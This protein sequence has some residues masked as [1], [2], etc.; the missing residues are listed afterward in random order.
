MSARPR[1]FSSTAASSPLAMPWVPVK[2]AIRSSAPTPSGRQ[3]SA[4]Q[5]QIEHLIRRDNR[6][7]PERTYPFSPPAKQP[8]KLPMPSGQT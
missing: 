2:T 7:A 3:G 8:L 1:R 5:H 6:H 4:G